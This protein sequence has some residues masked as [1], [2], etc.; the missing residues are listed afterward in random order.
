MQTQWA[1]ELHVRYQPLNPTPRGFERLERR[2]VKHRPHL[3]CHRSVHRG[4]MPP[5]FGRLLLHNVRSNDAL[6][7]G[8][9]AS[10]CRTRRCGRTS[11][12]G[13]GCCWF[14]Q[15]AAEIVAACWLFSG[16]MRARLPQR[17]EHVEPLEQPIRMKVVD[18]LNCELTGWQSQPWSQALDGLVQRVEIDT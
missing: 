7:Q 10:R 3:F 1:V 13:A 12:C 14:P 6:N 11:R 16:R 2:V 18:G 15:Q 8:V 17:V 5:G 9:D 4:E